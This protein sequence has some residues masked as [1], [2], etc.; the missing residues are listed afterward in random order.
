MKHR[1]QWL[2][3]AALGLLAPVGLYLRQSDDRLAAADDSETARVIRQDLSRTV[4]ATGVIRPVV[5]A[6]IDVGSRIS[7][8]VVRLPVKVGDRVEAGDLLAELDRAEL[9]A[10]VD[11]ARAELS[12]TRA[13]LTAA[14]STFQRRRRLA[15]S[16]LA[17]QEGLETA[18]RDLDV[19]SAGLELA[20]ARLRAAEIS[21]GYARI[22]AP[23]R[24]VVAAVT[25]R[26]GETVA[27]SFAAPTF[28]TIVD[29]DRLEVEAYV[30]E[31]DIG[32]IAVGQPATFTVDTYPGAEFPATVTAIQPKA[33]LQGNVV[34]Y[35]VTL[36]FEIPGSSGEGP[37]VLRP[38]MTAHVRLRIEEKHGVLTA[39]RRALR[40]RD[41][42]QYV[43]VERAGAFREQEIETGWRT[44]T[45]VEILDGL[46]EGEVVQ[47]NP[48]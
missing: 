3:L 47:L 40:R 39:P 43:V 20:E 31:T 44:D 15:A 36:D 23:I 16:G 8:R 24:G 34:N 18:R 19:E 27:A 22:R 1:R 7:G 33:E 32:R 11:Q 17:S 14:E 29:L 6:E 10:A 45:A 4:I 2:T 5:G 48:A 21:L 35:V 37:Y 12:L 9:A 25:T 42:R 30:D 38:E 28:V 13:R 46:E 26:E 41:G